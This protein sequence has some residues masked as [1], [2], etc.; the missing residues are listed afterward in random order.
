M[1]TKTKLIVAVVTFI[2]V[3]GTLIF[4]SI[5]TTGTFYMTVD[6]LLVNIAKAEGKP[7]KVSGKIVGDSINWDPDKFLLSF[8]LQGENNEKISVEYEGV[9]PDSMNDGWE[10]IVEGEL[11]SSGTLVA[12]ELLVKCPSKYEAME[13]NGEKLPEDHK[14][15]VEQQEGSLK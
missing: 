14:P 10:A 13:E 15:K 7:I 3:I 1:K 11:T 6:E 9:K 4:T 8:D 12:S 5:G 2:S